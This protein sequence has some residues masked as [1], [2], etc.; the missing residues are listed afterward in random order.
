MEEPRKKVPPKPFFQGPGPWIVGML[1]LIVGA[2][3][4]TSVYI[5]GERE[6]F[7]KPTKKITSKKKLK[8]MQEQERNKGNMLG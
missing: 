1:L 2:F 4:G 5:D 7:R 3:V 6:K 8:R